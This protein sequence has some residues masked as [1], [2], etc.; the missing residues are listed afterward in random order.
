MKSTVPRVLHELWG[1]WPMMY[2][3][4]DAARSAG[5]GKVVVVAGPD[6]ALEGGCR[7]ASSWPSRPSRRAPAGGGGRGGIQPGE[8]VIVLSGDVP[9]VT[10]NLIPAWPRR[11]TAAGPRRP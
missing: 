8:T 9:L 4:I 3:P 5:A 6:G 2:W 7:I 11:T 10:A 1:G